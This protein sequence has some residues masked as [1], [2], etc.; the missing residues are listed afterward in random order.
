[1]LRRSALLL[2]SHSTVRLLLLLAARL[3]WLLL[4]QVV[5]GP[6]YL[7]LF[8][9]YLIATLY[10]REKSRQA[11][12]KSTVKLKGRDVMGTYKGTHAPSF[13]LSLFSHVLPASFCVADS[14]FD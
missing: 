2:R 7:C 12:E 11:V 10:S 3:A 14:G 1:M 13:S 5:F 8:P 4:L 9:I 6:V